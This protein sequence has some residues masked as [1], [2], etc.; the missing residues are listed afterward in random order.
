VITSDSD[1][2]MQP[3]RTQLSWERTAFG[4][5]GVGILIMLRHGELDLFGRSV[6]ATI[7]FALAIAIILTS[8]RRIGGVTFSRSRIS[9][10]GFATVGLAT[11]IGVLI[12]S[13]ES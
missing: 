5:L 7:A 12:I 9:A 4:F 13:A 3:E 2:G 11:A 8:R 10:I 6:S 1:P